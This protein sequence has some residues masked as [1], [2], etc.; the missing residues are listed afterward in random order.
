MQ[1]IVACAEAESFDFRTA[2]YQISYEKGAHNF[3]MP[4]PI[5]DD[6][7]QRINHTPSPPPILVRVQD[8]MMFVLFRSLKSAEEFSAWLLNAEVEAQEGYRTMRG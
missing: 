7:L 8:Q 5:G 4:R 2:V 3:S 1:V 6:W